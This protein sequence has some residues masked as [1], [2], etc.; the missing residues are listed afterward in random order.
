MRTH[1]RGRIL[2]QATV[3]IEDDESSPA[4]SLDL[5][6]VVRQ[7]RIRFGDFMEFRDRF[8]P[9]GWRSKSGTRDLVAYMFR[10]YERA[11]ET[12]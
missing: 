1:Y 4:P 11:G 8:E 6:G 7:R 5:L 2:I 10:E 3:K 12:K 9:A